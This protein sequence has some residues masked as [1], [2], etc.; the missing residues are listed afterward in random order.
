MAEPLCASVDM[1]TNTIL[2]LIG[3]KG[4]NGNLEIIK[5]NHGIARLGENLNNT[6]KIGG[7]AVLR[8]A[9]IL[10][11]YRKICDDYGVEK[12]RICATS[13]MREA[14]NSD[15]V[16]EYLSDIIKAEVE[17]ISGNEEARLGYVGAVGF[18]KDAALLDI[19]GGSTELIFG[20]KGQ[21]QYRKSLKIGSVKLTEQFF[22]KQPPSETEFANAGN[23]IRE[24]LT[25]FGN[26]DKPRQLYAV[27]GTPTSIASAA[28][29]LHQFDWEKV[30]GYNLSITEVDRVM[31]IFKTLTAPQI[32]ARYGIHRNRA[33]LITAGAIILIESLS[34][35]NTDSVIVS[36]FG[37]RYGI[38]K[39]MLGLN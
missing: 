9:D 4:K 32:T 37:L 1:G 16:R 7:K 38:L 28:L 20:A 5:D 6:G 24:Q 12:I 22:P 31:D 8:A 26:I 25:S 3:R 17:I 10:K 23:F 15:K 14:S 19:G 33:D 11:G 34:Y 39:D 13:A 36:T 29:G 18:D 27:A 2:M 21:I 30:Q 35:L